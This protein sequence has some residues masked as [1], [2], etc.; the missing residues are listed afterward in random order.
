MNIAPAI[1]LDLGN[2]HHKAVGPA[3]DGKQLFREEVVNNPE[4]LREFFTRN[5]GAAVGMET[6][7]HVCRIAA[8][9]RECGCRPVVGNARKLRLIFESSRKNDWRD[10]EGPQS[11]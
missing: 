3:P 2:K 11:P 10:D 4:S 7:T 1:G 8:L 5:T 9:A 6:G